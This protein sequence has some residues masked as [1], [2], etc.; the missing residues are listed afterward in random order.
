MGSN[1]HV[2]TIVTS[3]DPDR[4]FFSENTSIGESVLLI[5]RRWKED[6]PKPPTRVIKLARNPATAIE[7]LDTAARIERTS[8]EGGQ[9]SH[10]FTIQ[11]VDSARI[12]RGDWFAVNF[13]SPFLVEAYRT[14][15]ESLAHH[16]SRPY[17]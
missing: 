1:Y 12:E 14:L 9:V 2:E 6:D 13:L 11:Q 4:I 8:M 3:H 10:D 15:S 7:S 5:C 16:L 17:P